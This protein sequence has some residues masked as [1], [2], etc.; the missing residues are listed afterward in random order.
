MSL[1]WLVHGW[2]KRDQLTPSNL[3]LIRDKVALGSTRLT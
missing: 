3:L 2:K 1:L